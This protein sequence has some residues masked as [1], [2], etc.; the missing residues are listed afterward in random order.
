LGHVDVAGVAACLPPAAMTA[1]ATAGVCLQLITQ[2]GCVKG[3][4]IIIAT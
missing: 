4:G 1:A 3:L 2:Q